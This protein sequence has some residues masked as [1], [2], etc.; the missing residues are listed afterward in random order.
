[1]FWEPKV[2]IG[3]RGLPNVSYQSEVHRFEDLCEQKYLI[4]IFQELST[5]MGDA[6]ATFNFIIFSGQS[7]ASVQVT[8]DPDRTVVLYLSD[9][10]SNVPASLC[11]QVLA[12]FKCFLP[13]E[14]LAPNL[15]SLPLGCVAPPLADDV[16]PAEHRSYSIFFSG[17]MNAH[18]TRL[19]K[20][21]SKPWWSP[22]EIP[23]RLKRPRD[24]EIFDNFIPG[25][26]LRFT[27]GFRTGLPPMDFA[28][29]LGDAKF[30]I[31]PKGFTS[32][33]T[34]RHFEAMRAGAI[35]ISEPL[36]ELEFYKSSPIICLN[37]WSDLRD[38]VT[39]L[40]ADPPKLQ[41]IQSATLLWYERF[42]S[43]AAVADKIVDVIQARRS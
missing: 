11:S 34:F 16:K 1:V 15:Y 26:Y 33:E 42:C 18:R 28:N 31:C 38:V 9:E 36:P 43:E 3:S 5:K 14:G 10:Q 39:A 23:V 20:T 8:T 32:A 40:L 35:V 21:L 7:E 19:F 4:G 30:A 41:S 13:G 17:A 27:N 6:F 2:Q 37:R 22:I 24:L 29:I 12:V 25:G